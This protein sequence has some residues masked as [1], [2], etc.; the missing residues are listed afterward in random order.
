MTTLYT[1]FYK[2]LATGMDEM[3]VSIDSDRDA[4]E[5]VLEI[6]DYLVNLT[7]DADFS[8]SQAVIDIRPAITNVYT[9]LTVLAM[10][11]DQLWDGVIATN[12]HTKKYINADLT[13]FVNNEVWPVDCV[14]YE[15]ARISE[16]T[17]ED[18]SGWNV[19]D[20]S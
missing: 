11:E 17:G 12:E 4:I 13:D 14:P 18:I 6:L 7:D 1:D 2:E 20:P 15:W 16:I 10:D 3:L 19:C 8:A 9:G 5:R